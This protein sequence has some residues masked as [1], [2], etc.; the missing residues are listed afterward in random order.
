S[1]VLEH[2]ADLR[3]T[4]RDLSNLLRPAGILYAEVPDASR[5]FD[6]LV[7]PFQD[8]N[9]EHINHFALA[10]LRNLFL[11]HGFSFETGGQKEI[12]SSPGCPYPVCYG[13]FRVR[14]AESEP[15]NYEIDES[16]RQNLE[17]YVVASHDQIR[18]INDKLLRLARS[19]AQLIVWGTG[20]LTMKLLAES[21]LAEVQVIAFVDGNPINQGKTLRGA[22]VLPPE[23]IKDDE[24]PILIATLLHY[25]E[26]TATIRETLRLSNPLITLE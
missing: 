5:Y 12:A 18:K 26:I 19:R 14:S 23:R 15:I 9:T 1:H 21:S 10:P 8:F 3:S 13:F 24:T 22:P 7:A 11:S 4:V 16:F 2:V 6:F 25:K 20:Q 17:A